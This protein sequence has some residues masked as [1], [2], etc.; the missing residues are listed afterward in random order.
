[1]NWNFS[2]RRAEAFKR[3]KIVDAGLLEGLSGKKM[4]RQ[5]CGCFQTVGNPFRPR[6]E[7]FVGW[8]ILSAGV[9]T[10]LFT[11]ETFPPGNMAE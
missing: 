9:P 6:A 10:L 1:M 3:R 2:S 11:G 8:K 7:T 5:A 4:F